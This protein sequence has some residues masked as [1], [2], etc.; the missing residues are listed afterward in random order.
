MIIVG[1]L[2][3]SYDTLTIFIFIDDDE[4]EE[5]DVDDHHEGN[6]DENDMMPLTMF[7]FIEDDEEEEEEEEDEEEE[8]EEE[9]EE[10]SEAD[11]IIQDSKSLNKVSLDNTNN[12]KK[13][14]RPKKIG[15]D[16][17]KK[18]PQK[19]VKKV[20]GKRGRPPKNPLVESS[21]SEVPKLGR[22]VKKIVPGNLK[23]K[24]LKKSE[25]EGNSGDEVAAD[26]DVEEDDDE[27]E[28]EE[29]EEEEEE[30]EK[31]V[32]EL[33]KVQMSFDNETT[34][35]RLTR[36]LRLLNSSTKDNSLLLVE[37]AISTID[38]IDN[39]NVG[40]EEL[41]SS[42]AGEQIAALRKHSNSAIASRAKQLRS[43]W[44]EEARKGMVPQVPNSTTSTTST[45]GTVGLAGVMETST[46]IMT[47]PRSIISSEPINTL[48][49]TIG[50]EEIAEN[51]ILESSAKLDTGEGSVE[52]EVEVKNQIL[53]FPP[54]TIRNVLDTSSEEGST[55]NTHPM[56]FNTGESKESSKI[57]RLVFQNASSCYF[58][59]YRQSRPIHNFPDGHHF[60]QHCLNLTKDVF[61]SQIV[62]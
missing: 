8:E 40:L 15:N 34:S 60:F 32:V 20:K 41:K 13:K 48:L 11:T 50:K 57:A 18:V 6:E 29:D 1:I 51:H 33:V 58:L 39:M 52:L 22:L 16:V 3:L 43:K 25:N 42:G 12:T 49:M 5:E 55:G 9:S 35:Q 19:V 38:K 2:E 10:N 26:D 53:S 7:I 28:E 30:D 56:D 54:I 47:G 14:G 27:E 4:E 61:Y 46:V 21:S 31:E 59:R 23:G 44:V 24:N 37:K 62:I 17:V 45:T 36:L